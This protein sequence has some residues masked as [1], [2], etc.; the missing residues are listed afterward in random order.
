MRLKKQKR[1]I[2]IFIPF[3]ILGILSLTSFFLL[4]V[5]FPPSHYFRLP[6]FN[7]PIIILVFL[8]LVSGVFFLVTFIFRKKTQGFIFSLFSTT[9]FL[10]RINGFTQ[11]FFL[12]LLIALFVV[13]E[14]F[15]F[16]KK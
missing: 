9:L 2:K 14:L 3:L 4:L 11:L 7:L 16:K 10:F 13:V 12:F 1:K 6:F 15:I 5:N 8:S